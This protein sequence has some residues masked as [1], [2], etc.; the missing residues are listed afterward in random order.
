MVDCLSGMWGSDLYG[1]RDSRRTEHA[2]TSMVAASQAR[3]HH[4]PPVAIARR[5]PDPARRPVSG[6]VAR[7]LEWLLVGLRGEPKV[8]LEGGEALR[9]PLLGLLVG[10]SG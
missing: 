8:R 3:G 6:C 2:S 10:D 4:P 7:R 5:Q 9:E 1:V